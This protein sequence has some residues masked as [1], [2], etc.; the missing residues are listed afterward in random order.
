MALTFT[1][2]QVFVLHAAAPPLLLVRVGVR[3]GLGFPLGRE[4]A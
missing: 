3:G 2:E 4:A 1:V